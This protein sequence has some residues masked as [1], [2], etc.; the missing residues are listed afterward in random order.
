[1][2]VAPDF[3]HADV[4]ELS[5][6]PIV[7]S[8]SVPLTKAISAL[9]EKHAYGLFVVEESKIGMVSIRDIL[10]TKNVRSRRVSSL[11]ISIPMLAPGSEIAKA[12]RIMTDYRVRA[13]PIV[14]DGNITGQVTALSICQSLNSVGKLDFTI[15]KIMT[16]HPVTLGANDPLAKAKTIMNRKNIDHLPILQ[17]GKAVGVLTSQRILDTLVPPESPMRG[18]TPE[19]MRVGQLSVKGLMEPPFIVDVQEKTSSILSRLIKSGMTCALVH[20]GEELQGIVTYR[21]FVKLLAKRKKTGPPTYIVGLPDDLFEAEMAREKFSR[22]VNFLR[23]RFP[24]ILEARATL[25]TSSSARK[26]GRKRYEVKASIYTPR[27]TF[28]YSQSGWDLLA[29]FDQISDGLRRIMTRPRERR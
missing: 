12:A 20:S 9:K 5:T 8:P 3:A 29:I 17:G 26:R 19:T 10:K 18:R 6:E 25:K 16:N 7:I 13:L 23:K 27:R 11:L 15:D 24:E 4:N 1:M 28:T 14:D 2:D 22:A 21:D